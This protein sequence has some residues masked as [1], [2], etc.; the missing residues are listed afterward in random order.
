METGMPC[1][2]TSSDLKNPLGMGEDPLKDLKNRVDSAC[3]GD[4]EKYYNYACDLLEMV[5]SGGFR[6]DMRYASASIG[7]CLD[8]LEK[9]PELNEELLKRISNLK[10]DPDRIVIPDNHENLDQNPI[11]SIPSGD[12]FVE[13]VWADNRD[14]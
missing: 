5:E 7:H 12:E 13:G 1:S 11:A 14:F 9:E 2:R 10:L 8:C 6:G 3:S 4:P